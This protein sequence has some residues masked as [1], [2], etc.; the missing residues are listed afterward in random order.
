[1]VSL[2]LSQN[3]PQNNIL[4]KNVISFKEIDSTQAEVWRRVKNHT[5][6]NGTIILADRQTGGKRNSWKKMVYRRK[7]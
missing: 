3:I 5:I 6:E 7:K 1:M 2:C 4:G